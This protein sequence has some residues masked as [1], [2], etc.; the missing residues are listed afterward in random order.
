MS[1]TNASYV[2]RSLI[3]K[4]WTALLSPR[5]N[6][7]ALICSDNM[8][9]NCLLASLAVR[10]PVAMNSSA[11]ELYC[12]PVIPA[13]V[14]NSVIRSMNLSMIP[15]ANPEFSKVFLNWIRGFSIACSNCLFR[16]SAAPSNHPPIT[17]FK[18]E[19]KATDSW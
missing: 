6:F 1:N 12:A 15:S 3:L 5:W 9:S 7:N 11:I 18:P 16:C 8:R 10:L 13:L 17:L 19:N 14:P 4:S 2:S